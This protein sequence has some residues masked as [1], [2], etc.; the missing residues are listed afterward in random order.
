MRQ[1]QVYK[2]PTGIAVF[3]VKRDRVVTLID[4]ML[5]GVYLAKNINPRKYSRQYDVVYATLKGLGLKFDDT[6]LREEF[7]IKYKRR[8]I[9]CS[10]F[11]DE[12]TIIKTVVF[13][14]LSPG[15]LRKLA[16][17]L[18]QVGWKQITLIE[19]KPATSVHA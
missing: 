11:L 3:E 18:I 4:L 8:L 19:L 15:I 17:R 10:L 7:V 9:L 16:R 2:P 6:S 13:T 5:I 12:K 14:S 1:I